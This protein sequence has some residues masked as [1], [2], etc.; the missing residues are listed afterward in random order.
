MGGNDALR[1]VHSGAGDAAKPQPAGRQHARR[2]LVA[3]RPDQA[4]GEDRAS[5]CSSISVNRSAFNWCSTLPG[6]KGKSRMTPGLRIVG[7]KNRS[8]LCDDRAAELIVNEHA[9]D[10][11]A[12]G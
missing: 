9:S 6:Q 1:E 12:E 2:Q 10:M 5:A 3:A 7:E 4:A 11:I 8:V